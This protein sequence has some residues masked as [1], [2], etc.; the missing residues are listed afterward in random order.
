MS[1]NT[2]SDTQLFDRISAAQIC[3]CPLYPST[4]SFSLASNNCM[5]VFLECASFS[6]AFSISHA[7]FNTSA[8]VGG[9]RLTRNSARSVL[10]FFFCS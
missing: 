6:C 2:C 8:T 1:R 10:P 3:H 9:V 4:H 5:Q 7:E